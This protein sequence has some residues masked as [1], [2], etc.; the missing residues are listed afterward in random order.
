MFFVKKF[1]FLFL[2]FIIISCLTSVILINQ[3]KATDYFNHIQNPSFEISGNNWVNSGFETGDYTGYD[4]YNMVSISTNI[5]HSGNYC[6][7]FVQDGSSIYQDFDNI[8]I[9]DIQEFSFYANRTSDTAII[10]T[11]FYYNDT[12]DDYF[13]TLPDAIWTYVNGTAELT[14]DKYIYRIKFSQ[15]TSTSGHHAF[16]DDIVLDLGDNLDYG[17]T[18]IVWGSFYHPENNDIWYLK[19]YV[20]AKIYEDSYIDI[21]SD[22]AYIGEK[23]C[24]Y[25]HSLTDITVVQN[26]A[27]FNSSL[28]TEYSGY[29]YT[30]DGDTATLFI[31]FS[32]G[33]FYYENFDLTTDTWN[34]LNLTS[35][36]QNKIIIA[37]GFNTQAG[38]STGNNDKVFYFDAFKLLS[39]IEDSDDLTVFDWLLTPTPLTKNADSFSAYQQIDYLFT[40]YFGSDNG[41]FT[42]T[43]TKGSTSGSITNG[44]FSFSISQRYGSG[45]LTEIFSIVLNGEFTVRINAL[46]I[47]EFWTN[48][49]DTNMAN[50]GTNL[51]YWLVVFC[52]VFLPAFLFTLL[53]H[54]G[55]DESG[56][57]PL[58][59]IYCMV[60]GLTL[61]IGIGVFTSIV[62]V[63]LL[64][65][66]VIV[67]ALLLASR[68]YPKGE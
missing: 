21:T 68:F 8:T 52:V 16:I 50:W 29:C 5:P 60:G 41:T 64:I 7:D 44:V 53:S 10:R 28:I 67:I 48:N 14:A 30:E 38:L 15:S 47:G 11:T 31:Y 20:G 27:F 66:M 46:W 58:S 65:L 40:G 62:P 1:S 54:E 57:Y 63:W 26:I 42:V 39:E 43:S 32:D 3:V 37:V 19:D 17:Q 59:P 61:S 13:D 45:N 36:P 33:S 34:Y 55:K 18:D 2:T 12:T 51:I 4:F 22:M 25:S 6:L 24:Y 56:T 49:T 23:S 35:I 9:N